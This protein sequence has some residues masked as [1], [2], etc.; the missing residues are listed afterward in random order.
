MNTEDTPEE[1]KYLSSTD[2]DSGQTK[3]YDLNAGKEAHPA[4]VEGFKSKHYVTDSENVP[5]FYQ[6]DNYEKDENDE[7]EENDED[8]QDD[9]NDKEDHP[10]NQDQ[11]QSENNS[12]EERSDNSGESEELSEPGSSEESIDL[13]K[14]KVDK[15]EISSE[16]AES[17]AEAT[18][19]GAA[20]SETAAAAGEAGAAT[21]ETAAAAE[22]GAAAAEAGGAAA[23]AGGAAAGAGFLGPVAIGC[24]V[25]IL[26]I[27]LLFILGII[28]AAL[29]KDS[30]P[31]TGGNTD[32]SSASGGA[33]DLMK[34]GCEYVSGLDKG[35]LTAEAYSHVVYNGI[36][37]D[38]W[39]FVS[40]SLRYGADSDFRPGCCADDAP[41]QIETHDKAK[42]GDSKY[43]VY[44][45]DT[46]KLLPGDML[47]VTSGGSHAGMYIGKNY[48]GCGSHQ[49]FQ[50]SLYGHNPQCDGLA[51]RWTKMVRIV[52]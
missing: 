31:T 2:D 7:D 21:A 50:A 25:I 27:A 8:D 3:Y 42:H 16:G 47:F 29:T 35:T 46:S 28:G 33:A 13:G 10:E 20:T 45:Y 38:C 26:V 4:D 11:S 44:N 17:G 49:T 22:A 51:N 39:G 19:A 9:E 15:K 12:P 6:R 37:S 43:E 30:D 23:E 36:P 1:K 41:N 52:N 24:L 32:S 14:E 5:E 34:K 48:C 40:A 18:E